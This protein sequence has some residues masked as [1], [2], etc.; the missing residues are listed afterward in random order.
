VSTIHYSPPSRHEEDPTRSAV[1]RR[2][3][4][5]LLTERLTEDQ[6]ERVLYL[7]REKGLRFGEAAVALRLV[8]RHEVLEALSRQFEYATGV[9]S[10]AD[11]E[12]VMAA[13]PFGDQADAFRELRSRL[14]L[15]VLQ[16]R[17]R[18][19]LAVVSPD[20]GDG[21]TYLVANL[22]IAFSQLG[23][24]TLLI[25]GD[26]RTPRLH[27]LFNV[28]VG[29]GLS[30]VLA[31]HASAGEAVHPVAPLPCLHVLSAGGAPPNPLELLQRRTLT[32]L[33]HDMLESFEHVLIDTPAASRGADCR[34]IAS[35]C[36]GVIVV[37]RRDRTRFDAVEGLLGSLSRGPAS[38]AGVVMNNH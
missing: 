10:A 15:E 19:A 35:R 5:E 16:D 38:V 26:V 4:G 20:S 25:D 21:K 24:R 28:P 27:R 17:P 31:G 22:A 1:P 30:K 18:C 14:L 36:G 29:P 9:P 11:G 3:L 6:V 2:R 32:G 7:Q 13:D 23:E 34:V 12:L 37:A 33:L 8:D